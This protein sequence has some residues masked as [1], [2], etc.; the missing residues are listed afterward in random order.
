MNAEDLAAL[1]EAIDHA[2]S[3]GDDET[4]ERLLHAVLS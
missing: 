1:W 4:A 3:V 2:R